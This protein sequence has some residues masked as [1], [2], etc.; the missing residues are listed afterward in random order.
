MH[1]SRRGYAHTGHH[2]VSDACTNRMPAATQQ[3]Q[4]REQIVAIGFLKQQ[5]EKCSALH[6]MPL[7][8][9]CAHPHQPR[10]CTTS[11]A[12]LAA[13]SAAPCC[14]LAHDTH[15]AHAKICSWAGNQ[16][17]R[18]TSNASG[19][20]CGGAC[21]QA[22][23]LLPRQHT[24]C[25]VRRLWRVC[26]RPAPEMR[27]VQGGQ[28]TGLAHAAHRRLTNTADLQSAARAH[29]SSMHTG[30]RQLTHRLSA[31]HTGRG[32]ARTTEEACTS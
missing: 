1:T 6:G 13:P 24:C 4:Q 2:E 14:C 20:G 27:C 8:A 21:T 9:P 28:R 19:C 5:A 12:D 18:N 11:A 10:Q 16:G 26:S 17:G 3:E 22:L 30:Q 31:A 15:H 7:P 23:P 25:S 32:G 29:A